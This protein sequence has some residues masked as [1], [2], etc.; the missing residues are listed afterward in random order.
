MG[1]RRFEL[2]EG[3]SSKFW[4][5]S[6]S[7]TSH[8]VRFGR[9]G[10]EGQTKVKSFATTESAASDADALIRAK[11]KKGYRE[12]G[13]ALRSTASPEPS[14]P[15]AQLDALVRRLA[16][17]K[18]ADEGLALEW[19]DTTGEPLADLART[20]PKRR[21]A[22]AALA[23]KQELPTDFAEFV[24]RYG[25]PD[26]SRTVH[27]RE[28]VFS[29]V[30]SQYA[31]EITKPKKRSRLTT[32]SLRRDGAPLPV[33]ALAD[34]RRP[35]F[36]ALPFGWIVL[37][38]EWAYPDGVGL[39]P[40]GA[41]FGDVFLT[42]ALGLADALFAPSGRERARA[43][44]LLAKLGDADRRV[45]RD[46]VD[47]LERVI[48]EHELDAADDVYDPDIVATDA[49]LSKAT[50]VVTPRDVPGGARAVRAARRPRWEDVPFVFYASTKK[51][52]KALDAIPDDHTYDDRELDAGD[53]IAAAIHE[54][55]DLHGGCPTDYRFFA[56]LPKE[57]V[58]A[59]LEAR[60]V[61]AREV[62]DGATDRPYTLARGAKTVCARI[63]ALRPNLA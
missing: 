14:D 37:G 55:L 11:V 34:G 50:L 46:V 15:N 17:T 20:E 36:V 29:L 59:A 8:T 52:E 9:I 23:K 63:A 16:A 26:L 27:G 32:R 61:A 31:S 33:F 47:R 10:T 12:V 24:A 51:L 54:H 38:A 53:A 58:L 3:A 56:S 28:P 22:L 1:G 57:S 4:E 49:S 6:V 25:F 40:A 35:A 21:Q 44:A 30:L 13:P 5:I 2:R 18:T 48:V 19:W 45:A 41:T 43:E 39:G 7:G 62:R 42:C 60:G